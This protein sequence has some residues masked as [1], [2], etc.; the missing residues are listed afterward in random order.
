MLAFVDELLSG[1]YFEGSTTLVAGISGV[2]KTVMALQFLAE[3][4]R[5][6]Q[7]GLMVT[8][9]EPQDRMIRNATTV[10]IDLQREIDRGT[11]DI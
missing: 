9:D 6:G 10:G 7:V 11:V 2:G 4:A 3:G 8:L 1:G 5:R